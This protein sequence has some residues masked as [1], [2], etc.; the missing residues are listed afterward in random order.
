MKILSYSPSIEAY[1]SVG[2][3]GEVIDITSDIVDC[4]VTRVS[5]ATSTFKISL[6]NHNFKYN[7]V[8]SPMDRIVIYATK[9]KRI[10]LLTGYIRSVPRYQTY[11]SNAQISGECSLYRLKQLYWDPNLPESLAV[12]GYAGNEN[13]WSSVL[14]NLLYKV[15]GFGND[16]VLIGDMP[17]AAVDWAIEIYES[18]KESSKQAIAMANEFYKILTTHG[19]VCNGEVSVTSGKGK[20]GKNPVGG[21][22]KDGAK[23]HQQQKNGVNCGAT[24]VAV[25]IN[26]MLGLDGNDA[27]DNLS[28]WYAMDSDTTTAL[29]SKTRTFLQ[30]EGLS[31]KLEVYEIAEGGNTHS[32]A[33]YKSELQKGNVIVSSSGANA[34]F[35]NSDGTTHWHEGHWILFYNY[36]DGTYY[37]NDSSRSAELGAGAGYSE[38]D[39]QAWLDGRSYHCAFVI[40]AK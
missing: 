30:Q 20:G 37:A 12:Q 28:V 6:Q 32:T 16:S 14:E 31:D 3:K 11:Q 26:I 19:P 23:Y 21:S 8:F 22:H 39:L 10:K 29:T 33:D 35:K 2:E 38:S 24:S 18:K 25:G 15:A 36:S 13:N 40:A 5:D 7:N 1:V 4:S 34:P 27:Y 17:Q 9:K